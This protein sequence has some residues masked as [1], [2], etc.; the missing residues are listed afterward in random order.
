M[1]YPCEG[2][3]RRR[4]ICVNLES[5]AVPFATKVDEWLDIP[6]TSVQTASRTLRLPAETSSELDLDAK[7]IDRME[8]KS[9]T[10]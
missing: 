9:P 1:N 4:A 2:D 7:S 6:N 10:I 5:A 8:R 3:T